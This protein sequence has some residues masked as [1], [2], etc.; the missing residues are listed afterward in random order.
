MLYVACCTLQQGLLIF[1]VMFF[2]V[3]LGFAIA[4]FLTYS[5]VLPQCAATA[6]RAHERNT[7]RTTDRPP[8]IAWRAGA[9][10][11]EGT[12]AFSTRVQH[13]RRYINIGRTMISLLQLL[14]G[15]FD[16]DALCAPSSVAA[17]RSVF[18]FSAPGTVLRHDLGSLRD[19]SDGLPGACYTPCATMVSGNLR[20]IE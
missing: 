13:M 17:Q 3:Y 7:R 1:F 10:R 18:K 19:T 6:Q 12:V 4:F 16:F 2:I 20:S 8:R 14:G 15:D 9:A 5:A 11:P